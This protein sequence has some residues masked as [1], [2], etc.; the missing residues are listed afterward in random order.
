MNNE[1]KIA[2][3]VTELEYVQIVFQLK[4]DHNSF[5]IKVKIVYENVNSQNIFFLNNPRGHCLVSNLNTSLYW[6]A[7]LCDWQYGIEMLTYTTYCGT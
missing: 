3:N 6:R 7:F 5:E 4:L 2:F 1:K